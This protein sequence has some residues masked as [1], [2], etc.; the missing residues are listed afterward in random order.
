MD[1][2]IIT[3]EWRAIPNYEEYEVSNLGRVKRL[4]YDKPVCG[5]SLQHCKERILAL[6]SRKHG[7]QAVMLSK[8]SKVKS[9]LVHRLVA[10]AFIPNP[11]N[12]PHINHKDENPSN[13]HVSN[14]EWC[15]QKY[16][17]NYGTSKERIALKL[18]NGVLSKPVEQ[19]D[20]EGNFICDY[21]SAIEASRTL[22]LNVSGIV[23]CCNGSKKYSHC[24]G[25]QWKYKDSDKTINNILKKII[26]YTKSE[27]VI[28]IYNDTT[29]ASKNTGVSR[30]SIAN[31]LSGLSKTAGGFIW[32]KI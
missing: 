7:Y 24:G 13:N 6:Q 18:K 9:F 17:S 27:K 10:F 22:N 30:T 32:K 16:N 1:N 25:F 8:N 19:Y 15:N 28:G 2:Q 12:L 26:Q 11:K 5:G 23:A 31:C 20:K 29:E 3:E 14:L 4:A 21:P